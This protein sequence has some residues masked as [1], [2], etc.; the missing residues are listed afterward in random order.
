MPQP[1]DTPDAP[2][3]PERPAEDRGTRF[4]PVAAGPAPAPAAAE[5]GTGGGADGAADRSAGRV[6]HHAHP[7]HA[8]A[9]PAAGTLLVR[10][11][12]DPD[13][14]DDPALSTHDR[15]LVQLLGAR[16][17]L[18]GAARRARVAGWLW[19]LAV[20][21]LGGVLRF[22]D[23][24]RPHELV[25][26]ETYYVK[27]AYS[28]LRLGYEG[29]WGDDAN[30]LF[31]QG[32]GSALGERA[33]YVVHPPV[34]K[35]LIALGIQLGGGI[36]SSAAWRLA[37]AVAGTLA[38]LLVA[39]I[40]RR[41]LAS[42][43]LGTLAGLLM[44]VD[45]EAIVHSRTGLLDNFVMLF[46]LA[47]FGALLLDRDQARRRLAARTAAVLDSGA[48]LGLGPRLGWR[49][50]RFAAAVLLGLCI[51]TKWSG[52]YFLAVFGLLSVAWDATARRSV[53]VRAWVPATLWRDAIPAGVVVVLTA[54]GTYL[55]TWASWFAHPGAYL[56]QWAAEHPGEGVTWLPESLRSLWH[57]HTQM[58]DFHTHLT[59]EHAYAA[60]PLGW[61]IQWR[62]TSFYYPT[63]VSGLTGDAARDL[64]GADACSQAVT[65]LGNPVIW[66]LGALALLVAL[67]RL[68]VRRDW[69]AG[70]V[71]SGVVAGW[72][73]WFTYAERTIFTFYSIAFT[74]WVVLAGVYV[75]AL[76]VQSP[77]ARQRR[78][79]LVVT[80]A[81][82]VVVLA[83][84]A[85]FYP[86]WTAWVVPY[87]V[88]HLH[89]WLP[90]WI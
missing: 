67:Y 73:P 54:A 34:G 23:L 72:L 77:D 26:D 18:L 15:L 40:A 32:D 84:S 83:V 80:S 61:I 50:W 29:S 75:L 33:E 45:G 44:A 48:A 28:L 59:A 51:G 41:L 89:M 22:W 64:C 47:A 1:D 58:F 43:A 62:P 12:A 70:A 14:Q 27:Q 85:F 79:G 2:P 42:T 74:P 46:A 4:P 11:G 30:T 21:L 6:A 82:V 78:R 69:R 7:G 66:W 71:L 38:V 10:G 49:W 68:L 90:S 55:G 53:G 31:A 17:L 3:G 88:W 5:D 19:P 63:E 20:T 25:F 8:A 81:V 37:S 57:F 86:V 24:G 87:D 76:L 35:W 39:R 16:T 52:L 13:R 60:H 65:S 36:G 56:R 9:T